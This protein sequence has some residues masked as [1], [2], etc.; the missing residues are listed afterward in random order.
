MSPSNKK[1]TYKGILRQVF[2]CLRPRIPFPLPQITH[3]IREYCTV[4]LFTQ[5]RGEGE[6]WTREKVRGATQEIADH[7]AASCVEN[8]NM[9]ECTQETGDLQS[10]NSDKN[11]CLYRSIFLDDDILH[12]LL[13]VLSLN[14][15]AP[16]ASPPPHHQ[17][18]KGVMAVIVI[19]Y[20]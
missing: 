4:Y 19:N 11:T 5:G 13:W 17:R 18:K 7:T 9:T 10:I 16:P 8:T 14:V 2:I 12:W 1:F 20:R 6:S 3:C 15:L